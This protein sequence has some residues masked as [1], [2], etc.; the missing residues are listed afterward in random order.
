MAGD[1][2]HLPTGKLSPEF[3]AGLLKLFE[4]PDPTVIQGPGVGIDV[5]L[6]DTGAPQLLVVKTDPITFATDAIGYYA[7]VV[8]SN[9]IA[10]CGGRPRWQVATALLPEDGADEA[11]AE[12]IFRQLA[13]ACERFDISHVGGHTEVTAGLDRPILVATML[14]EVAR[15]RYVTSAGAREGDV[16]LVTKAA[17]LEGTSLIAREFGDDLLARGLDGGFVERCARML[18]EPGISVLRE[19]RAAVEAGGVHAMH[20]PTEGGLATGLWEMALASGKRLVVD[21]DSVPVLDECRRLCLEYDLDPLGLIASGSLLIA[22]E[23]GAADGII[24]AVEEAGVQCSAIGYVT[25]G[26]A[27]VLGQSGGQLWPLTR[28]D[29]DELTKLF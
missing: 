7:V 13:E 8:N 14:G 23:E 2:G 9:D 20:D 5:A 15:D 21:M 1:G 16:L 6:L 10:T 29:Q 19:A 12:S 11:L 4:R 28:Y 18:H 27:K 17:A 26:A 22:A 25:E 24:A 3:L